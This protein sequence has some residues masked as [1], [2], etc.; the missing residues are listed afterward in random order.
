[1]EYNY[2]FSIDKAE[3]C[4]IIQELQSGKDIKHNLSV[5]MLKTFLKDTE[6]INN[7]PIEFDES[8]KK[9]NFDIFKQGFIIYSINL[10]EKKD[11]IDI[12][13]SQ[14]NESI[15]RFPRFVYNNNYKCWVMDDSWNC[16][17]SA[18]QDGLVWILNFQ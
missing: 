8:V 16:E 17:N 4:K 6:H 13:A 15:P 14:V 3:S 7:H 2:F 12:E 11:Y 5:V 18:D 1:M 10:D 9:N